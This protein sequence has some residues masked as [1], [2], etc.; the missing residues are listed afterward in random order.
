MWKKLVEWWRKPYTQ[1]GAG[2][3]II[4][5][6]ILLG[7]GGLGGLG[8][9][10]AMIGMGLWYL[11]LAIPATITLISIG[12]NL[13]RSQKKIKESNE[14]F[15]KT[16]DGMDILTYVEKKL[17]EAEALQRIVMDNMDEL[18]RRGLVKEE[19]DK[20]G[21]QCWYIPEDKVGDVEAF[22][23]ELEDK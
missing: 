20:D 9:S 12:V 23:K 2:E 5:M 15:K 13:R 14:A 11:L 3:T 7:I 17:D 22:L 6:F 1:M 19:F 4:K 18:V 8:I 10:R 16:H 21:K